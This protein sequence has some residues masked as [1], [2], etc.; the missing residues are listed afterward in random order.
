METAARRDGAHTSTQHKINSVVVLSSSDCSSMIQTDSTIMYPKST[1]HEY[2][3]RYPRTARVPTITQNG[4]LGLLFER[5]ER[6]A[7]NR[8]RRR[9]LRKRIFA[10]TRNA[11]RFVWGTVAAHLPREMA[12]TDSNPVTQVQLTQ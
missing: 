4:R 10:I 7:A 8:F 1:L 3:L 12:V 9:A 5:Q 2:R 11:F 6:K